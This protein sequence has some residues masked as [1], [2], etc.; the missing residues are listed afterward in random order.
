ML[1]QY[2]VWTTTRSTSSSPVGAIRPRRPQCRARHRRSRNP[3]AC[4]LRTRPARQWTSCSRSSKPFRTSARP[5]R[6]TCARSSASATRWGSAYP[7]MKWR[8]PRSIPRIFRALKGMGLQ[9][10]DLEFHPHND[11]WLV[12]ANCLAAIR[13]GC[14]VINGTSLGKGERTGNAPLEAVL[15]HLIGMGY[16]GFKAGLH[17]AQRPGHLYEAMDQPIPPKIPALRARRAPHAG[18]RSC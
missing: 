6:V 5:M 2:G 13:E 14:A 3:P 9:P 12:V 17:R 18:R 1:A 8:C 16:F 11:T 15:M 7:T 4:T 10:E